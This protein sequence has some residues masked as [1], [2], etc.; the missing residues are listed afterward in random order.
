[1]QSRLGSWLI[2]VLLSSL[3]ATL[4]AAPDQSTVAVSGTVSAVMKQV[5][6]T[7]QPPAGVGDNALPATVALTWP[8]FTDSKGP[9]PA[10]DAINQTV[11]QQ[12][13][14]M[15]SEQ[16]AKS[17]DELVESFSQAY[18]DAMKD[19]SDPIGGWKLRFETTLRHSDDQVVGL[20]LLESVFTGGA[21]PNSTIVYRVFSLK[22]GAQVPLSAVVPLDKADA[23]TRVAEKHFRQARQ[24]KPDETYEQAGFQFEGGK[25]VLN[26]NYLLSKDGLAFCYN[27]Y[28][29]APYSMGIT[30]VLI[31]WE[32]LKPLVSA[33]GP[34][35]RF[36]ATR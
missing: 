9:N 1:M 7:I 12:V 8:E 13:L 25:F 23:L 22:S 36:V 2:A 14:A 21:H 19:G 32:D 28:E 4:A 30:T 5:A 18:L 33:D 35:G 31:P 16:P 6:K 24:L 26:S 15:Y 27:Q 34:A 3:A 29:I 17:I 10:L 20:E 11:R